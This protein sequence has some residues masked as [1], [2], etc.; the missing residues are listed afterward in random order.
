MA[1]LILRKLAKKLMCGT[2]MKMDKGYNIIILS[3]KNVRQLEHLIPIG[4][5]IL[6]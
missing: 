6:N 4:T 1:E 2:I 3:L 5:N